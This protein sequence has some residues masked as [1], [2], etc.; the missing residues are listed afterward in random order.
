M[1]SNLSS[2]YLQDVM[3]SKVKYYWIIQKQDMKIT[4]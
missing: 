3:L 4:T 2:K 1:V